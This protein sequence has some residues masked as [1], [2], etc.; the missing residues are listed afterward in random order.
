[1][2]HASVFSLN[3]GDLGVARGRLSA[4][5]YLRPG[6]TASPPA[7]IRCPGFWHKQGSSRSFNSPYRRSDASM[8]WC[9]SLTS[10][11]WCASG[12]IPAL[13]A[14]RIGSRRRVA[15]A[16][17]FWQPP[18]RSF[19]QK[20]KAPALLAFIEDMPA[21][22][23]DADC[24]HFRVGTSQKEGYSRAAPPPPILESR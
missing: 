21:S 3:T 15:A 6:Y 17:S 22:A 23:S 7:A 8:G 13:A 14:P 2:V 12:A 10:G 4:P 24:M 20:A 5:Q 19:V 9:P 1:M 18:A 16:A 11:S